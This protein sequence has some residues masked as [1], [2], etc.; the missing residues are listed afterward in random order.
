MYLVLFICPQCSSCAKAPLSAVAPGDAGIWV[1]DACGIAYQINIEFSCVEVPR[2][3]SQSPPA[4]RPED[5][6][7]AECPTTC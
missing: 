3:V 2:S 4:I 7:E 1:C 5:G 6:K